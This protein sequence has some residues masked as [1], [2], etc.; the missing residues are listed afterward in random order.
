MHGTPEKQPFKKD[1]N[2]FSREFMYG[3]GTSLDDYWSYEHLAVQLEDCLDILQCIYKDKYK[4]KI[5]VDHSCGHDQQKEDAL[6]VESMNR[7]YG[8]VKPKMHDSIMVDGCLGNYNLREAHDEYKLKLGEV[9]S[10][11]W[12]TN[13]HGP[14]FIQHD[15]REGLRVVI[16]GRKYVIQDTNE[17]IRDI[18]QS[19]NKTYYSIRIVYSLLE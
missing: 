14:Y 13:N 19:E 15:E 7:D 18:I 12:K 4:F 3:S 17:M 11:C 9:Q 2:P 16:E 5:N 10:L 8:G 1:D 6:K